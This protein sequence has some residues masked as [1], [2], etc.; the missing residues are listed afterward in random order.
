MYAFTA[1]RISNP[2]ASTPTTI[3]KKG[4][5]DA[6]D[7]AIVTSTDNPALCA[8]RTAN[9]AITFCAAELNSSFPIDVDTTNILLIATE[10]TPPTCSSS[11]ALALSL[12]LSASAVAALAI[13]LSG[14]NLFNELITPVNSFSISVS[15]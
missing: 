7:A 15:L 9:P 3:L 5:S 4:I 2:M 12:A 6:I 11:L 8:A 13:T 10:R 14:N 1:P